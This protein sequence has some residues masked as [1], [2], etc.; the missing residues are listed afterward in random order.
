[1]KTKY[2]SVFWNTI[3]GYRLKYLGYLGILLLSVIFSTFSTFVLKIL[4][5]I[6][7]YSDKVSYFN[8]VND[9]L[10]LFFINHIFG[11][12]DFLSSNLWIFSILIIGFAI[13]VGLLNLSRLVLS[14]FIKTA[15][16]KNLQLR[17]FNHLERLDYSYI[18]GLRN[19]DIIQTCTTDEQ[20]LSQFYTQDLHTF[21]YTIF[22]VTINFSV[23]CSISY[24]VALVGIC[25]LPLL[26]IYSFFIIKKVH[27]YY[28]ISDDS[29]G[30]LTAKIEESLSSIRLVK[31]YNNENFEINDFDKYLND[32]KSKYLRYRKL[33]AF[34]IS[35]S[36]IIMFSQVL[37]AT[38]YAIYLCAMGEITTATVFI[39]FTYISQIIWP[40]RDLATKFANLAKIMASIDR[41]KLIMEEP[42]E[43]IDSGLKPKI[44]G[45]IEFKDVSFR[46]PD[47]ENNV[48]NNLNFKVKP[49][50]TVAIIGKTGSGKSTLSY[51]LTRLYDNQEG[52]I[53]LD[54]INIKD[55]SKS[56]LR[57][58]IS[59]CLQEPFLFSKTIKE[60]IKITD[61]NIDDDQIIESCEIAK[62]HDSILEF[63]NQYD[64]QIGEKGVTLSGGQKQRVAI[65]RALVNKTP[66]L[67]FDDSLSAVDT[68]TDIEIR[69][70]L[71]A[72]MKDTTTFIITH[73]VATAKD[74]DLIIVL[75]DNTISEMGT[76]DELI[77]KE[78]LFSR[79]NTIQTR[80]K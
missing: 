12:Y 27:K 30:M 33:S 61:N 19:G 32:Y 4:I 16:A 73:R 15:I 53:L 74:A 17:I 35:S 25:I 3:K 26:F 65:A 76:Y 7:Q 42:L 22:V 39:S 49:G 24:K 5:D 43:D 6:L 68:K 78:G 29:E 51:L 62:I 72:R 21:F 79:I 70:A 37:V 14:A 1:M 45:E 55:I 46:F 60:N 2:V 18:K 71:K 9:P 69:S 38:A 40:V 48:L 31:A 44:I 64:T 50:Q 41:I 20:A 28:R 10:S 36:D 8:N 63:N 58:N 47:D 13:A 59:L 56:H 52:E 11:G 54:G 80:M 57:K 77:N 66:L 23:L 75:E 67:I 34:F